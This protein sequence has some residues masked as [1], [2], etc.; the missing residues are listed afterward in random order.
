M[1]YE[2]PF[3]AESDNCSTACQRLLGPLSSHSSADFGRFLVSARFG[4]I[5][6]EFLH[7]LRGL[8]LHH[9]DLCRAWIKGPQR[10]R[11]GLPQCSGADLTRRAK[12]GYSIATDRLLGL[13][14]GRR[15]GREGWMETPSCPIF[16]F[17]LSDQT[18]HP[19]TWVS[20]RR[21]MGHIPCGAL[22][23]L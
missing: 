7:P 9:F 18:A 10:A 6:R 3:W 11:S 4:E 12:T 13:A 5:S 16:N 20:I 21:G 19:G 8:S 23:P 17:L 14:G 22:R 1:P 2:R 15:L